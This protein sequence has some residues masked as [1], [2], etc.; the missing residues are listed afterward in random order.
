MKRYLVILMIFLASCAAKKQAAELEAQPSWIKQKP[1]P[2]GYYIGIGS[3]KKI[4]TS[5]QYIAKARQEA[6]TDLAESVSSNVSSTSVLHSIE[7]Q[8]G[9]SETFDQKIKISTDD[10]LEGFD[11]VA[12]YENEHSYWVYYKISKSTYHEMKEKKK[13][14]AISTAVAKY[15]SGIQEQNLDKPQEAL[16]FYLQG[17]QAIK[18]Y[19]NEETPTKFNGERIDIGNEI[20]TSVNDIL[21][22]LEIQAKTSSINVKRGNAFNKS[23]DYLVTYNSKPVHGIPVKMK[24]SGGYLKNDSHVS[25]MN[26]LVQLQPEVLNSR[27]G[28]G[29]ITAKINLQGLAQKSVDDLFIRGLILK[30]KM[31]S[32]I[33]YV[34][35]E[36][37]SIALRIDKNSCT[38]NNCNQIKNIF[39]QNAN[40]FGY[41]IKTSESSDYIFEL[42]FGYKQGEHA[43]GLVSVYISGELTIKDRSNNIIWVKQTEN[44]K[45][46]GNNIN[47]AKNKAFSEFQTAL[48]R[49]YFKQGIDALK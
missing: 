19:L 13:Q 26:G 42:F 32:A 31:E 30:R 27:N 10:Y 1:M 20:Y 7:T 36:A 18:R 17:L 40:Q 8:Y 23:L 33:T 45:G 5:A 48:D 49:K 47:Q 39:N 15:Q 25:D 29:R 37:P 11:P 16:A 14:E 38:E 35:I 43:G 44:V 24:Y 46:V 22:A 12:F 34:I 3:V 4:G 21:N 2:T 9:F 28:K 6:L 41:E